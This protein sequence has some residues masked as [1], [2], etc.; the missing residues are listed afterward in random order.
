MADAE[1]ILQEQA[2]IVQAY[3]AETMTAVS[4]RVRGHQA[5]PSEYYRMDGVWLAPAKA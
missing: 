1:R 5:D 4:D 3:W 2:V